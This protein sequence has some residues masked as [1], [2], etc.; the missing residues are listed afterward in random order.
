MAKAMNAFL[1]SVWLRSAG[2]SARTAAG[3]G[4]GFAWVV[5]VELREGGARLFELGLCLCGLG[6]CCFVRFLGFRELP[7]GK[8]PVQRGFVKG[9]LGVCD[10]RLLVLAS[11]VEGFEGVELCLERVEFRLGFRRLFCR[12]GFL[13]LLP[14][15][16]V[17][18]VGLR[19]GDGK[20][21]LRLLCR[22]GL[23]VHVHAQ[24]IDVRD[25]I[26]L[27]LLVQALLELHRTLVVLS[28][29][30]EKG[31]LGL[32]KVGNLEVLGD[33]RLV[34]DLLGIVGDGKAL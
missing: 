16:P 7:L 4:L 30:L 12:L 9:L 31:C 21:E 27:G 19:G 29:L 10:E 11:D 5:L 34:R 17:L 20:L 1:S 3:G 2:G 26:H 32:L 23:L 6:L 8:L 24:E 22:G 18:E 15:Q 13:L 33:V 28:V 25:V 14:V